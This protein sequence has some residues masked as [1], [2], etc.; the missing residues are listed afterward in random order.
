MLLG[1]NTQLVVEGVVPDLLHVVP[2]GDDAV[3]D[4]VLERQDATLGLGL[5]ADVRVLL[6]HAD[7]HTLVTRAA[8]DRGEHSARS[9]IT[10]EAG[11]AHARTVVDHQ[12]LNITATAARSTVVRHD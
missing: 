9:I 11:L 12:G 2:V 4:G 10:S 6:A 1:R 3:L 8:H 7:H 5:V